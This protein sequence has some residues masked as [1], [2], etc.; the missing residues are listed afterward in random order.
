[1]NHPEPAEWMEYLYDELPR[2]RK[3]ELQTHLEQCPACA[4]QVSEW[5]ESMQALDRFELA[6]AARPVSP[7][8]STLRWAAAAALVDG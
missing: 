3:R 5:R 4:S 2:G 8:L 6:P 7:W 1:M